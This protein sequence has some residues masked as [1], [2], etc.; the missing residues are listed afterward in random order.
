MSSS[1]SHTWLRVLSYMC[2]YAAQTHATHIH[3]YIPNHL[4]KQSVGF[5][6]SFFESGWVL[7][8]L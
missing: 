7:A 8:L 4:T 2:A 3:A 5:L 6:F 1:G